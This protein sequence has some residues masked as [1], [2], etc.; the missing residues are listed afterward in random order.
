MILGYHAPLPP[1]ATGVAEY[2]R[3]LFEGLKETQGC[4]GLAVGAAQADVQLCHL[5]NN[6]LH[7]AA[8]RVVESGAGRKLVFLHDA[9]L[10]HYY[11]GVLSREAYLEEF[12]RQYG[13]WYRDLAEQLWRERAMAA[14]DPRYFEFGMLARVAGCSSAILVH[15]AE[16][17]R[18][19]LA[20][21]PRAVVYQL[22]H[23]Y[24]PRLA[25]APWQVARL[26]AQ[27]GLT[28]TDTLFGVFG[29]L[30]E[31]KRVLVVL[32][33][34]KRLR[35]RCERLHLLIAGRAVSA[36]YE[37]A[38]EAAVQ[39]PGVIRRGFLS[40]S[41]FWLFAQAV[42]VGINLRYPSCG[43]SSAIAVKLMG[44]GKAVI[45]TAS[46]DPEFP[47]DCF[48]PVDA[49]AAEEEMLERWMVIL[50]QER[51]LREVLGRRAARWIADHHRLDGVAQA[52]WGLARAIHAGLEPACTPLDSC[53]A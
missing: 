9:T 1:A 38:I 33:V 20:Q 24:R 16:A 10:H 29:H 21:V 26:R 14:S 43:E 11:L 19:V 36:E 39:Q 40:E 28:A 31:S 42:D 13:S 22:P 8:H 30:R 6:P 53:G 27:M 50:A 35:R 18:R 46:G 25:A 23:Y 5:G 48:V 52:I 49:G 15:N 44:L 32:R 47:G 2:A 4:D 51:R 34:F 41:E 12:C 3:D 17:R 37:R 7:E 45:L